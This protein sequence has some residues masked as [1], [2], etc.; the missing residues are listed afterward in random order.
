LGEIPLMRATTQALIAFLVVSLAMPARSFASAPEALVTTTL[1]AGGPK[2][3]VV[4]VSLDAKASAQQGALEGA[5]ED[6][7]IRASR[8]T[9]LLNHEAFNPGAAKKRAEA[10]S[11][12][13]DMVK[14]GMK[15]L[16]ELD[17][18]KATESFT[19]AIET[20]ETGDLSRDFTALLEAWTMKAAGH[21]TGGENGPAKKDIES[22]IGLNAKA[23]FSPTYF[24]PDLLKFT[25]AQRKL[26]AN[27]KGELLVRTEPAGARVWVDGTYRGVSPVSVA[28]LTANKH[29][30]T[31]ALGGYALGQSQ[32]SPGEEVISLAAAELAPGFKKAVTDIKKDPEGVTRDLAAQTL[33]KAAQLDQVLLVLAKKSVAGEKFDLIALRLETRDQHNAAYKAATVSPTDPEALAAFFDSLTGRDAKRDGKEPVHH[34]KGGGG[35]DVKTIAGVS[36]LGLAGVSVATGVVFGVLASNNAAAYRTTPQT[37][38]FD[39]ANLARD[40]RT[41]S[42]VADVSY[43]VA[44]AAGATGGVLLLT[45]KGGSDEA[46]SEPSP[47]NAK[48]DAKRREADKR[49]AEE[50]RASEER[51]RE[52]ERRREEEKKREEER[53]NQKSSD[54]KAAEE[55]KKADEEAKKAEEEAAAKKK[56]D[57]EAANKK[58]SK[59]EQRELEKKKKEEERQAKKEEEQRKK[60]EEQRKKDEERQRKEDEKKAAEEKKKQEAEEK[61]ANG[62]LT[63]KQREEEEKKKKEEEEAA[64]KKKAEEDAAAARKAEEE[65]KKAEEEKKKKEAEDKK[66]KDEDHDDLRNY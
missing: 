28:G 37:R 23:E 7:L 11:E 5:A 31:A 43:L 10:L 4:V 64:A 38:S 12:A 30:V 46:A 39:S 56:A 41:F 42:I 22:V 15:S 34:F 48:D 24:P 9:V 13:A 49:A 21:A 53:R 44:I 35:S 25:E 19:A 62:K 57:E 40:G 27:A 3:S 66:K 47:K 14:F 52:D 54:S 63:K 8:F 50:R 61:A 59:K 29:Y 1:S 33:G 2:I 60:E 16:E 18:V 17:N 36:L 65:K 45:N 20:L 6:A 26:T 55:K 32:A 51:A 58:L